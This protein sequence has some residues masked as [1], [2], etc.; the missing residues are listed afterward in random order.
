MA[1]V[2]FDDRDGFIWWDGMMIPWRDAK[3]HVLS[4]GLHYA[5]AVFE[6]ER[7]YGGNIFK[8]DEHTDRLIESGR[9]LGFEIPFTHEQINQ[10]CIDVLKANNLTDAYLRPLAWRGSEQLAVSAQLTKIHLMVACW[11]W[12]NLFGADRMKGVRL[13]IADWRRP[14]PKTAPTAAKAAGLYMIGTMSKHKAEEQGF[15]DALMYTW[16]GFVG[17]VTGANIFFV[18]DGKLHTPIPDCFLDGITRKTVIGLA[19]ARGIEVI[20]RHMKPEEMALSKEAFVTGTAAEITP[21]R[22]I[23]DL[24]FEPTQITEM[25]KSDYEALVMMS[26]EE[27]KRRA[28]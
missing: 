13:G 2:P 14:H 12:P 20:E 5:S 24:H 22:Q 15:N 4:H 26:P 25:L 16:D 1:L 21:V 10:A 17:E 19:K 8:L 6:G 28:A 18:I 11:E 23:G 27:V 3:L 9:I 7:S